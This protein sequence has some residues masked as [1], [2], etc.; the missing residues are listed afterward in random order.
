MR[1]ASRLKKHP[2]GRP[3][4]FAEPSRPV[5]VTLPERVLQQLTTV[6]ADRAKAITKLAD[7]SLNPGGIPMRPVATVNV[8]EGRAVIL[9][10]HSEPLLSLPWLRL[11]EVAPARYLIS[12]RSGTPIESMEVSLHDL[13]EVLPA[14]N[15]KDREVIE[16]LMKIFRSSR[17][18]KTM[19]KEEI[20]IVA[21]S[22]PAE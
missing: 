5:T 10:C 11:I 2:G 1:M 14:E 18:D 6:D 4:K 12:I 15:R 16:A 17:R 13:L 3:S 7:A 19:T 20:F 22:S 8:A 21:E 9:V